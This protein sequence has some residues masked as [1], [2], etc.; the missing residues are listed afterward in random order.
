MSTEIHE[1]LKQCV[2]CK[3]FIQNVAGI[4]RVML[5]EGG[6]KCTLGQD[7]RLEEDCPFCIEE[8]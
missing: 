6:L 4:V 3:C 5:E 2:R 8:S 7:P 1:R